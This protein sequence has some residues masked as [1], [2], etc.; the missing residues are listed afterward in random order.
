M[1]IN[2][3]S[4]QINR[5]AKVAFDRMQKYG[6]QTGLGSRQAG[7]ASQEFNGPQKAIYR[8][9]RGQRAELPPFDFRF[10]I[11]VHPYG[12]TKKG[13]WFEVKKGGSL[14]RIRAIAGCLLN[15][16]SRNRLT[17]GLSHPFG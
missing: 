13:A 1:C 2:P 6:I 14:D 10:P 16:L 7:P 11:S 5:L 4:F 8:R 17:F 12:L 3:G 15:S 9:Y